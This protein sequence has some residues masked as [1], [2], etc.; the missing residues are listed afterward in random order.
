ML[1]L[2][3]FLA[4]III[5]LLEKLWEI[6]LM[7][8]Q[9]ASSRNAGNLK[10]LVHCQFNCEFQRKTTLSSSASIQNLKENGLYK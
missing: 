2:L 9:L 3:G 6:G 8:S 4:F 1:K 5:E 7:T 10:L